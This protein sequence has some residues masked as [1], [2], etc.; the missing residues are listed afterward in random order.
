MHKL[1]AVLPED[2]H[3]Y[4]ER[5]ISPGD[6]CWSLL[7]DAGEP[8]LAG[9][10]GL[11]R[12][13]LP[14]ARDWMQLMDTATYLPDDILT[15]VDRASMAVG[16]EA[17]VQLLDHRVVKF[18]WRLATPVQVSRGPQPNGCCGRSSRD[19]FRNRCTSGRKW[20]LVCFEGPA[21]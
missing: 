13:A 7:R 8:H 4:Y 11:D 1:A 12:N 16:L 6:D 9:P 2:E 19:T 17:R 14:D 5:L 20:G 15:K 21:T 18:A 10:A 3:G